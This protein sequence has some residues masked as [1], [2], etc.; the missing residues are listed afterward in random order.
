MKVLLATLFISSMCWLDVTQGFA[1]HGNALIFNKANIMKRHYGFGSAN[2]IKE[3]SSLPT[4]KTWH[5]SN[6]ASSSPSV[7]EAGNDEVAAVEPAKA[8]IVPLL[9]SILSAVSRKFGIDQYKVISRLTLSMLMAGG[10]AMRLDNKSVEKMLKPLVPPPLPKTLCVFGAGALELLAAILLL[11]PRTATKGA[12]LT[13][14]LLIAFIPAHVY[15]ALSKKCQDET[16]V[17]GPVVWIRL[18]VQFIF[19]YWSSWL[20]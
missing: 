2:Y 8:F 5:L 11:I 1:S 9:L 15:H 6:L 17:T 4:T 16:G 3:T 18:F 13:T 7:D 14:G 20:H 12:M 10:S 19:I